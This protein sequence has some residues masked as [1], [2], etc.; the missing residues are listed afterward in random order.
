[1]NRE[2]IINQL[3]WSIQ[4]LALEADDQ[5]ASFPDFVVVTDELLLEYDNWYRAAIG[6]YPDFFSDEQ[7]KILKEIDLFIDELPQEDL[8]VSIA[9]ELRT[10]PFWKEL[11]IL[12]REALL[13]FNWTSE[14]PPSDRSTYVRG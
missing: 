10:Y 1:M 8:N 5:L 9:D 3:K 2:S 11:R 4:T 6:N 7:L 13:K 14:R 12:A